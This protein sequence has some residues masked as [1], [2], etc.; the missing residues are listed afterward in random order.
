MPI[1]MAKPA[2]APAAA[3]RRGLG[4]TGE[5]AGTASSATV[6][7]FAVDGPERP[8]RVA[9]A[10]S[11][12]VRRSCM[13]SSR[14]CS[15]CQGPGWQSRHRVHSRRKQSGLRWSAGPT[16][17]GPRHPP[18]A[19]SARAMLRSTPAQS[20]WRSLQPAPHCRP[21][22]RR[23]RMGPAPP[24]PGRDRSGPVAVT[25]R[26]RRSMAPCTIGRVVASWAY[27]VDRLW[28]IRRSS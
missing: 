19:R 13:R 25:S 21:R 9:R 27:K 26:S 28:E 15:P 10:A 5:S 17:S 18:A 1:A 4:A 24:Q 22:R 11:S 16:R 2:A 12:D 8:R 3:L 6:R 14:A 7:M 23:R 20:R